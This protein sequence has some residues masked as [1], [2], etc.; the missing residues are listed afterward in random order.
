[1]SNTLENIKRILKDEEPRIL[2]KYGIRI[3][4]IFGSYVRNEQTDDSDIDILI[5]IKEP[6]KI[7]LFEYT[8]LIMEFSKKLNAEVHFADK[9]YLKPYIGKHILKEVVSL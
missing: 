7:G 8:G 4:G 5:E 2:N 9:D 1:M 3:L 6:V